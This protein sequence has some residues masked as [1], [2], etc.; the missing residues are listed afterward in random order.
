MANDP[1]GE[2]DRIRRV[3]ADYRSGGAGSRW[4]QDNPGYR[5]L[6]EERRAVQAEVLAA[7]GMRTLAERRVLDVGCGGGAELAALVKWGADP[8]RLFG[9]DLLP[10]R[11]QAARASFPEIDFRT[12][13]A[14]HLD[15][16]DGAFDLVMC[17]T[18]I[19]SILDRQMAA[20]VAGEMARVTRPGGGVLWYDL[21][22]SNPANPNVVGVPARRLRELFPRF[23]LKVR[24]ISL[25]P[26]IARRLGPATPVL[27]P[28]LSALPPFRS[29]LIGF[30]RAPS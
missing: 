30:L 28:L 23:D 15:Y 9:V 13:N 24:A 25:L 29:H 4:S 22:Y 10:D 2:E 20:Q 14:E 12:G 18:V 3:Y 21:R 17:F 11:V 1:L 6:V 5:R 16:P 19:S 8:K 7:A 26:P 27:Y